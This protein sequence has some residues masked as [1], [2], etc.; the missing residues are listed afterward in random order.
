MVARGHA[1]GEPGARVGQPVPLIPSL[2]TM[3]RRRLLANA[4]DWAALA[5]LLSRC[6]DVA[7]FDKGDESEAWTLAHAFSDLEESFSRVLEDQLPRLSAGELGEAETYALLLDI[8][9]ELRHIIYHIK[10]PK[11]YGYLFDEGTG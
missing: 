1:G 3:K 8:G 4:T 11:F 5:Q 6:R 2:E 7:R 9:E 10:D